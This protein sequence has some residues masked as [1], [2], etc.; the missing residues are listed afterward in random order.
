MV[1]GRAL[2]GSLCH[3]FVVM[4]L[5]RAIREHLPSEGLIFHSDREVQY[6]CEGFREELEKQ[7]FIQNMSR[8]ADCRDNAVAESFFA[9][10]KTELVYHERC[11]GHQD[12]LHSIFEY[13]EAFYNRERD[14]PCWGISARLNM[15]NKIQDSALDRIHFFREKSF[16]LLIGKTGLIVTFSATAGWS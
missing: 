12:S 15:K 13:I 5:Q 11:E 16:S 4:A 6:A 14:T 7:K 2:T 10:I 3:E 9:M 8:K 1:T